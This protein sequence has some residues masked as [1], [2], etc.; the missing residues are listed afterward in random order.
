MFGSHPADPKCHQRRG[1]PSEPPA[2]TDRAK[3]LDA[4]AME[5]NTLCA[6]NAPLA[7]IKTFLSKWEKVVE[8]P[9]SATDNENIR[10]QPNAL[11]WFDDTNALRWAC[12]N[13]HRDLVEL[14]L[15]KGLEVKPRAV[16]HAVAKM[17]ET[18]DHGTV[19]LLLDFGWDINKPIDDDSLPIM[20]MVVDDLELVKWCLARGGDPNVASAS[21]RTIMGRAAGYASIETLKL[22]FEEAGARSD[23]GALIAHASLSHGQGIPGRLEVVGFL[24]NQGAPIDDFYVDARPESDLCCEWLALGGQNALHFAI[25][26]G[27]RDMVELLIENGADKSVPVCSMLKTDGQTLCPVELAKRCTTN[28]A[29]F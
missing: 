3:I 28:I 5:F 1:A 29:R 19:Q 24:I 7:D 18:K 14:L 12:E 10:L 2:L 27:M 11:A 16:V 21:G 26:G 15:R 9:T 25:W 20:S 23:K 6:S 13:D 8:S 4:A 17:R 22:L